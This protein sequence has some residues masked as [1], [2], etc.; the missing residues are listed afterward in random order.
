M[1][2]NLVNR[3]VEQGATGKFYEE[4]LLILKEYCTKNE[5]VSEFIEYNAESNVA[6]LIEKLFAKAPSI[7]QC[8]TCNNHKCGQ[9]NANTILM[10]I[11]MNKLISG[12]F[13]FERIRYYYKYITYILIRNNVMIACFVYY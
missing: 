9:S 7:Y 6:S 3:L 2:L 13:I 10:P 1:T 12:I 8:H 4:R 11:Y 5:C